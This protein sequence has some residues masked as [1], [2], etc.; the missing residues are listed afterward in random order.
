MFLDKSQKIDFA[1][2]KTLG[3]T[4]QEIEQSISQ[5]DDFRFS[6][7]REDIEVVAKSCFI[8]GSITANQ[9]NTIFRRYGLR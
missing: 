9:L 8:N 7:S 1:V 2:P 4:I 3:D 6:L 5:G